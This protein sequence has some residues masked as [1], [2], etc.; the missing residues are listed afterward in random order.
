MRVSAKFNHSILYA[1]RSAAATSS[2]LCIAASSWRLRLQGLRRLICRIWQA[3][4]FGLVSSLLT[5][6]GAPTQSA[7][8]V[9]SLFNQDPVSLQTKIADLCDLLEGRKKKPNLDGVKLDMKDC[10]DAGLAAANL[11]EMTEFKF[12][13]LDGKLPDKDAEKVFNRSVRTQLWLNRS[14]IAMGGILVK[15]LNKS[16]ESGSKKGKIEIPEFSGTEGISGLIKPDIEMLEE[17]EFDLKT[18]SFASEVRLQVK[19]AAEIDNTISLSGGL[20]NNMLAVVVSS[21]GEQ[22]LE[23][24]LLRSFA[25]VVLIVPHAG[26]IYLDF[27]INLEINNFGLEAV[28]KSQINNFLGSGMKAIIDGLFAT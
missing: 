20:I 18:M 28:V 27:F 8:D 21:K 3:F 26:D 9:G 25:A 14:L 24:S 1:P 2:S 19:G 10:K 7:A 6:C 15:R 5:G 12:M 23:K 4:C 16:K 17:P 13:G 11:R 22:P